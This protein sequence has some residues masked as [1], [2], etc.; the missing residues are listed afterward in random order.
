MPRQRC[1]VPIRFENDRRQVDEEFKEEENTYFESESFFDTSD[2]EE[3]YDRLDFG[4]QFD[5]SDVKDE[6]EFDK[7]EQ[8]KNFEFCLDFVF[9]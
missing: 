6:D 5:L 3:D 7:H 9:K 8:T 1:G 2:I 4:L